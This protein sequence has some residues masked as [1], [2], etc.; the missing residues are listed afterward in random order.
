MTKGKSGDASFVAEGEDTPFAANTRAETSADTDTEL[1]KKLDEL[2]RLVFEK[3]FFGYKYDENPP[4]MKKGGEVRRFA[5][6]CSLGSPSEA[7][8]YIKDVIMT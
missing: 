2:G 4:K 6:M 3:K 8:G 1:P 7:P 5:K